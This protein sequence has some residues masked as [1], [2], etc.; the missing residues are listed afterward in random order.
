MEL[1]TVPATV[2]ITDRLG[3]EDNKSSLEQGLKQRIQAL[4]PLSF[5]GT[6]LQGWF[7]Q[8]FIYGFKQMIQ[9]DLADKKQV[10]RQKMMTK[11]NVREDSCAEKQETVARNLSGGDH[12][13]RKIIFLMVILVLVAAVAVAVSV[14]QLEDELHDHSDEEHEHDH[15]VEIEGKEMKSLTIQEIADLWEIDSENLLSKII[16]EFELEINYT[17]DTVLD[18][19]RVEYPFS[20]AAIKNIAEELKTGDES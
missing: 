8:P 18:T 9:S 4:F 20:P 11:N 15:S 13:M 6:D 17:V 12:K 16:E 19:M 1:A 2:V 10:R 3:D 7:H 14:S 5:F